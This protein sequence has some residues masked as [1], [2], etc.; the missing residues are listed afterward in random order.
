MVKAFVSR[1]THANAVL[2]TQIQRIQINVACRRVT[3]NIARRADAATPVNW[4]GRTGAHH[5]LPAILVHNARHEQPRRCVFARCS[6]LSLRQ[7]AARVAPSKTRSTTCAD[8]GGKRQA[9]VPAYHN[10]VTKRCDADNHQAIANAPKAGLS[11]AETPQCQ[12]QVRTRA[13]APC[14]VSIAWC[15]SKQDR[16]AAD[17]TLTLCPLTDQAMNALFVGRALSFARGFPCCSVVHT[18]PQGGQVAVHII[19]MTPA[20]PMA[21]MSASVSPARELG[22]APRPPCFSSFRMCFILSG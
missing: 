15:S 7:P 17:T 6:A 10:R 16:Q 14:A 20:V 5:E 9:A 13:R 21:T 1:C 8:I 18:L 22:A 19:A 3:T 2:S 12:T 11:L 4:F